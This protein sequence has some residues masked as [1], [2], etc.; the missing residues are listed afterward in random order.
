[1]SGAEMLW[2]NALLERERIKA[3]VEEK[4]QEKGQEDV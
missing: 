2:V 1:M 3:E 4:S